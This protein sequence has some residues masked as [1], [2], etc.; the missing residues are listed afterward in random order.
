MKGRVTDTGLSALAAA[1]CGAH[2]TSLR[3]ACMWVT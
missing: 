1:G 3:L 2:L